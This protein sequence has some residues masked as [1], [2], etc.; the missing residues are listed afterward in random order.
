M[1]LKGNDKLFSNFRAGER[2]GEMNMKD[3]NECIRKR[4]V[5][6]QDYPRTFS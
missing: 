4:L 3:M 2:E 6:G 5:S 1:R